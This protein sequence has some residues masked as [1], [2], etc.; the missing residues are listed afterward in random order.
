MYSAL[1]VDDDPQ[2]AQALI[3]LIRRY[4]QAKGEEFQF[5]HFTSAMEMLASKRAYDLCFLDIDMPGI[6]GM[7][8]A[9]LLRSYDETMPI[10]FVTNLA[11]FAVHGYEVGATGFIVKPVKYGNLAMAMDRAL[12]EV[13]RSASRSV[14][15]QTED[16]LHVINFNSIIYIDVSGH[17]LSIHADAGEVTE[18]RGSL[19][20]IEEDLAGAPVIRISKSCLVN[21]DKI[22]V[23]NAAGLRMANGDML[24]I[25]RARKREI[26][27]AITD[28]LGGRR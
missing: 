14:L 3:Q 7:E 9:H 16:G 24:K 20:Q 27:D 15:A 6:T 19:A 18:M 4:G 10:V 22:S 21:M 26:T 13:N 12:R 1:I 28:Y 11:K 23:I 8:A 5:T 25:S 2:D 17:T